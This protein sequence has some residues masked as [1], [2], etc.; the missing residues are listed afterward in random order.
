[1]SEPTNNISFG[2]L[3]NLSFNGFNG[4]RKSDINEG[5]PSALNNG[6]FSIYDKNKDQIL[7]KTELAKLQEDLLFYAGD[8]GQIGKREAKRF[9]QEKLGV[10]KD[11]NYNREDL[12]AIINQIAA[13]KDN[14]QNA[15]TTQDGVTH[16]EFKPDEERGIKSG[17]NIR[18]INGE[19]VKIQD[20]A[21]NAELRITTDYNPDGS[22]VSTREYKTGDLQGAKDYRTFNA[23]N[24]LTELRRERGAVTNYYEIT[25]NDSMPENSRLL[26]KVTN[27][28]NLGTE[29]VE[30]TYNG[31]GT[32]TETTISLATPNE[33]TVMVKGAYGNV[34]S[35]T[36]VTNDG[37]TETSNGIRTVRDVNGTVVSQVPV[38]ESGNTTQYTHQVQPGD[39]WY[40][41][42]QAKYGITDHATTMA[43]VRALKRAN[44]Y[45]G[46]SIPASIN[47]PPSV[48]LSDGTRVNLKNIGGVVSY[49]HN[50]DSIPDIEKPADF[51]GNFP[52]S[53]TALAEAEQ[54][55]TIPTYEV[56]L[57]NAG[58]TVKQT[59]GRYF[60]YD[61]SGRVTAVYTDEAAMRAKDDAIYITY[62]SE[63]NI[64]T[65]TLNTFAEDGQP[66][67]GIQYDANG[68]FVQRWTNILEQRAG[69]VVESNHNYVRRVYYNVDGTVNNFVFYERGANGNITREIQYQPDGKVE[70]VYVY[71]YGS[72]NVVQETV[73]YEYNGSQTPTKYLYSR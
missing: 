50:E 28:G 36:T 39:T 49:K 7:D 20:W 34:I 30:Y 37:R 24:Q 64:E 53:T 29:T 66:L 16:L 23:E 61:N 42:V 18:V 44:S 69:V 15:Y 41:I 19:P 52:N 6:I 55:I 73:Q 11:L 4:I 35:T 17:E 57:A 8:N 46:S 25:G 13:D 5:R 12:E 1:M 62:D 43:V 9:I 58:N 10:H 33:K 14:I 27:N 56:V 45:T 60:E 59:D 2:K 21:E 38:D 40:G 51:S 63:G 22:K 65:Y 68:D 54:S 31:D 26:R 32:I 71:R 3:G 48:E 67:K 70:N 72:S 47:L